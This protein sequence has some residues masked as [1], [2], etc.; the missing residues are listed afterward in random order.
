LYLMQNILH[1]IPY[2]G[3][4][5]LLI[6]MPFHIFLS[7]SLS[8]ATGGLEVWKAGKD[9][10]LALL[11]VFTV[12]LVYWQGKATKLFNWLFGLSAAYGVLYLVLWGA[13]TDIHA[14]SAILG[15][16]HNMRL[17]AFLFLGMGAALLNP[18]KFAFSLVFKVVLAVSTAVAALGILQYF[19]P[20]DILTH[21]GYS[22]ERGV[23]PAFFIDDHPDLPRIMSTLREPNVLGA[24]LLVPVAALTALLTRAKDN[25]LRLAMV[26]ALILHLLAI[27]LTFSRS[28]WLATALVVVLALWWSHR[29]WAAR[30]VKRLW[31]LL[32][33]IVLIAGIVVF[34]F[35]ETSFF[36]GYVVHTTELATGEH[37]ST[38]LHYILIEEG[39]E[40]VADQPVGYGPG[41][42]G[43]ASIHSPEGQLTENYYLQVAYE[44]GILGLAVFVAINMLVYIHLRRRR[45]LF[46][47]I[48]IASFWGYVLTNMLLHTWANET[49]AAQWWLLAGVALAVRAHLKNDT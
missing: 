20:K 36:Q 6:Y 4:W 32:A 30:A 8:L 3:F 13:N 35:R 25:R 46:G 44:V 1:R 28:A 19:L 47:T 49:V 37:S 7:Q 43:L 26:G 41:T 31:P 34:S 10:L 22:L 14:E 2:W 40:E 42:A 12:C 24:Y 18:G 27:F 9:V 11:V 23:R 16:V 5:A 48:L 17:P 15:I 29:E 21:L 45:D 38:E 33:V 39:V